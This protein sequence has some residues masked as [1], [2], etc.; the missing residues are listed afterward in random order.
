MTVAPLN[1]VS[2]EATQLRRRW[3][4]RAIIALVI[5]FTAV[6]LLPPITVRQVESRMDPV[7]GS[8]T[9]KTVWLFGITSGPQVD[10]S[11]LE[12][13]L[14]ASGIEWTRSWRFLHGTH[15]NIFGGATLHKCGVPPPIYEL[16]PVLTEFAAAS[17]DEE[18]RQFA[19]LMQFGTA[20]EQ[21]A[22][23]DAAVEKGLKQLEA[24]DG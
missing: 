21:K 20:A 2:P 3:W 6:L 23:I 8:M 12:T 22:A 11:P 7:T 19:S 17:T 13:R 16:R 10:V 9:R 5:V 14:K 1:H 4:R 15:R 24:Q 18:L